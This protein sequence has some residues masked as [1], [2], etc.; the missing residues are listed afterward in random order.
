MNQ[1]NYNYLMRAQKKSIAA[2]LAVGDPVITPRG[3]GIVKFVFAAEK[4]RNRQT[5]Y[6]IQIPGIRLAF[7]YTESELVTSS[8]AQQRPNQRFSRLNGQRAEA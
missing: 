6:A 4:R 1:K 3:H 2:K 5:T 7:V 8:G